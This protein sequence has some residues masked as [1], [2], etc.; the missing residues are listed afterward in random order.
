MPH[1]IARDGSKQ[2]HP[3]FK[4]IYNEEEK[5]KK[6]E[7]A[8]DIPKSYDAVKSAVGGEKMKTKAK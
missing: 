8:E 1:I 2:A 3:L 5:K 4:S 6:E 7:V